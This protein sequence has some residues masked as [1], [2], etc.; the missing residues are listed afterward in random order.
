MQAY[1]TV[2]HAFPARV[3]EYRQIYLD[4]L[5][6]ADELCGLAN[7]QNR[8]HSVECLG[9]AFE[10]MNRRWELII[11]GFTDRNALEEIR[12]PVEEKI[13]VQRQLRTRS[14]L[15]ANAAEDGIY[16]TGM[17]SAVSQFQQ[18]N[19]L[20]ANGFVGVE[21]A[22]SILGRTV[23]TSAQNTQPARAN[24]PQQTLSRNESKIHNDRRAM[25]FWEI[26]FW[27]FIFNFLISGLGVMWVD[28]KL[29]GQE[30]Y[31]S[32]PI[33]MAYRKFK[34]YIFCFITFSIIFISFL[35]YAVYYSGAADHCVAIDACWRGP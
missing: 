18:A 26:A 31:T 33:S 16:G 23:V 30:R 7:T 6:V 27:F 22:H 19:G 11:T 14:F 25:L 3:G 35:Y 5:K 1:Y 17:R 20:V 13:L 28:G 32:T 12:M 10:E 34:A 9:R 15:S 29:S 8:Q 21:T 24:Y 4:S 2:R